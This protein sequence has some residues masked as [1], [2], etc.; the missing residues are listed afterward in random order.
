MDS[1]QAP[2]IE[3]VHDRPPE[4]DKEERNA[5]ENQGQAQRQSADD[6]GGQGHVASPA[7]VRAVGRALARV[8]PLLAA[9]K[10]LRPGN[11]K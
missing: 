7:R 10:V 8:A 6:V 3:G 4:D 1:L 11:R 2:H 9:P 5:Q